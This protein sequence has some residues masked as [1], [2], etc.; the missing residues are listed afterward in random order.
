M[1]LRRARSID[2]SSSASSL[3]V[4]RARTARSKSGPITA[5]S[6]STAVVSSPSR[7]TRSVTTSRTVSGVPSSSGARVRRA[8]PSARTS[9]P[10]STSARHSSITRNAFPSVSS[11]ID[12]ASRGSSAPRS[13]PAA[14]LTS[15][16]I[17]ALV[18]PVRR[19]GTTPSVRRRSTRAEESSVGMS[20]SRS[21]NV[22]TSSMRASAAARDRWRR[23]F[24]VG[25]SAQWASSR[26]TSSGRRREVFTSSSATAW[27]RRWR[28]VS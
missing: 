6:S 5:A 10:V 12:A 19:I 23:R 9:V 25:L 15:S 11:W 3:P 20:A 4:P 18:S 24:N 14:W 7:A 1:P 16:A 2:P 8:R 21:R 22:A 17:S 28:S 27:W 13:P 26:I